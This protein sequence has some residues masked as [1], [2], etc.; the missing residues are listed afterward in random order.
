MASLEPV[1]A[2]LLIGA[3][4]VLLGIFSSLVA[5]RFG[6]PLL[7][8]F[9]V[10]GM[11]AGED[12]PG[13][14]EFADYQ[15]TYLIGSLALSIIL[16]DGGLRTRLST[17]RGALAPALLLST[18]GVL[19]TAGIT[20]G[21]AA[22]LI[23][24]LTPLQGLLLG[25]IVAST[26]AAA[27]F[28]LLRTGGLRLQ[29]RVGSLLE[30]ESGTNDPMAVFLVLMLTELLLAG[31]DTPGWELLRHLAEQGAIGAALGLAGGF[32]VVGLL[33]R[34]QMPGGLHPLF[35]VA[36][37]VAIYAATSLLGGSGL[38]AV[39][40]AGLVVANRPVRAYPS[41]VGFHDAATWLCQIV[42]FIVLGLLVTPGTLLDYVLPGILLALV[43]ILVAR[44]LAVWLCL[45]P[46]GF[47]DKEKLFISWV[48]LRGAVSIFLAAIPTLTGVAY[49][50]AFFNIAFFVVLV[51]LLVQGW[52]LTGV[53]RY[54]GMALR[55]TA[56]SVQRVELDIPGQTEREMVGYPIS[57]DS[58]I[59]ALSRLPA[60][61]RVV[62]VV[63]EREILSAAEAGPLHPGDYV[64][65]LTPPDRVRRLDR[66]FEE[67]PDV[68]RRLTAPFGELP[69][70]GEARLAEVAGL[71]GLTLP[72]AERELTVAGYFDAHLG[73]SAQPGVRLRLGA[74]TLVARSLEAG[75][76]RRAGLQLDELVEELVATAL[77]RHGLRERLG[78][79]GRPGT[80]GRLGRRLRRIRLPLPRRRPRATADPAPDAPYDASSEQ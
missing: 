29:S 41:I 62:L 53:A 75:R 68:T 27:V 50:E 14:I 49:G 7:L 31:V 79:L 15:A 2:V 73:A 52:S 46:F 4:L 69:L 56:P 36:V 48:G 45:W 37:A 54:L 74:A 33:N 34:V 22:L 66:L 44:P 11:L 57:T 42:M 63:R 1:N 55:R 61:A 71:Y 60:W 25:A 19:I 5:T 77:A 59:L 26:D 32:A 17:F 3:A 28:F 13:G 16:F 12:G 10:V 30:I 65:I 64:Y 70:N 47:E 72:D 51:S 18:L 24:G 58:L 76:V 20:G 6:A 8:V 43:L 9:L 38:L 23:G 21:V 78:K 35:V 40:L 80:S 67:S 39:Y